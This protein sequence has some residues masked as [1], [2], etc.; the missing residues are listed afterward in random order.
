M[1]EAAV[2]RVRQFCAQTFWPKQV[3]YRVCMAAL[4]IAKRGI[5]VDIV[6]FFVGT[7]G[8]GLSLTTEHLDAMLGV[9]APLLWPADVLS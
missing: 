6:F 3:A 7:G 2:Q 9:G 1:L 8:V 5:N 4:A